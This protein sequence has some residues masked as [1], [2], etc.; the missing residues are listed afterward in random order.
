M[1]LLSKACFC[2][3]LIAVPFGVWWLVSG[4]P[5]ASAQSTPWNGFDYFHE[6]YGPRGYS[7]PQVSLHFKLGMMTG[8]SFTPPVEA[9]VAQAVYPFQGGLMLRLAGVPSVA[10]LTAEAI[11]QQRLSLHALPGE[12]VLWDLM[13]EWDQSG[14]AWVAQGRP[15]YNGLSRND[16]HRRFLNY[17]R[18]SYPGLMRYLQVPPSDRSYVLASVTDYSPNVFDGYEMGVELQM[19]E[20]AIDELGDLSTGIAYIR[21]AANQYQRP[22]GI[23]ISTWRTGNGRATTY[24]T[25]GSLQG[26]WSASYLRRLTYASFFAG[27]NIIHNEA[28][29]Y[30]YANGSLNPFGAATQ[31]FADFA[32]RRHPELGKPLVTTAIVVNPDSGFDP[33]HGVFDQRDAVWYQDIPYSGGDS[34]M[35]QFLRLAYPDHWLHGLAP[36]APF[37]N[38]AGAPNLAQFQTFLASGMDPRPY[39][40]TPTT[41]WG[42]QIDV[43]TTLVGA[44]PLRRYKRILLMGDVV[45]DDRLRRILTDWTAAGGT[46]VM[47]SAQATADDQQFAGL[48]FDL[49][50]LRTSRFSRWTPDDIGRAEPLYSYLPVVPKG[51]DVWAVTETGDPLITRRSLGSGQVVFT[52]PTYLEAMTKDRLLA[53]GIQFL[54][55]IFERDAVARVEGSSIAFSVNQI[56]GK[57]AV[58]LFNS[59]GTDW[60]GKVIVAPAEGAVVANAVDY[61]SDQK[62]SFFQADGVVSLNVRV[63][64]FGIRVVGIETVADSQTVTRIDRRNRNA[65]RPFQKN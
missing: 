20:R 26:G 36:G 23:D 49:G 32:L 29:N 15:R 56:P 16:A 14:G 53:I 9:G 51:A 4:I 46:L 28:S 59:E 24:A 33:K 62:M 35:N 2:G 45:L 64:A 39:E 21:G 13:P 41:R 42:D 18:S 38:A 11:E 30:R 55:W 19:L 10:G 17:Y 31:E 22:W 54:D 37:A 65:T 63:P 40:P 57:T 5:P 50:V 7:D 3:C 61:I 8:L 6:F 60:S 44:E 48:S 43:V 25:N 58:A 12:K 27:A 47:N 1:K 52:T 34:M